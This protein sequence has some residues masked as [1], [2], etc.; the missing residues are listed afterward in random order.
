RVADGES[1]YDI[2]DF[3]PF[4]KNDALDVL[5][6]DMRALGFTRQTILA[7][8]LVLKPNIWIAP[9]NWGSFLGFY[10]QFVLG[11]G[12]PDL[13]IAEQDGCISELFESSAF[14]FKDG[15][16]RVPSVPGCGLAIREDVFK[17]KYQASAWK[18]P[19]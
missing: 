17:E 10:M 13:L 4:I 15:K 14:E 5:Q 12:L 11:R 16:V 9:H 2:E 8:K 3:D 7:R 19:E 1:C 6:A 18:V